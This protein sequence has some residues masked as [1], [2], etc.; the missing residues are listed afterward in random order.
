M[1]PEAQEAIPALKQALKDKDSAARKASVGALKRV[2]GEEEGGAA[3][4]S[5]L[6]SVLKSDPDETLRRAAAET[7]GRIGQEARV[8]I[9][10]LLKALWDKDKLVPE[11]IMEALKRID[12]AAIATPVLITM[13][14]TAKS[15]RRRC[16]A[17]QCLERIG[18]EAQAAIPALIEA[19]HDPV[20]VVCYRAARAL[21]LMG[22][23]AQEALKQALNDKYPGAREAAAAALKGDREGKG[24]RASRPG[25]RASI[26]ATNHPRPSAASGWL[27]SVR[28]LT[29]VSMAFSCAPL[30]ALWA[31]GE[32]DG[33][34]LVFVSLPAIPYLLIL[35]GLQSKRAYGGLVISVPIG[36]VAFLLGLVF[37]RVVAEH[38][39]VAVMYLTFLGALS[40]LALVSGAIVTRRLLRR[41]I[42]EMPALNARILIKSALIYC[43]PVLILLAVAIPSLL[44]S[45]LASSSWSAAREIWRITAAERK[46]ASTYNIGYSPS[47]AALGPPASGSRPSAASADLIDSVLASGVKKVYRFEYKPGPAED[48]RIPTYTITARPI[49]YGVTATNSYL[50][51]QTGIIRSTPDDRPATA[52]D[53]PL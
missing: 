3:A 31:A 19:L 8:A 33:R 26:S 48:G 51:D 25:R 17:A 22:P 49:E 34:M 46:Y 37:L 14:K 12:S 10:A 4:V 38:H 18:H 9:P 5:E 50:S 20:K 2:L 16:T 41:E 52:D 40:Q 53:P 35:E 15:P 11:H 42:P 23:E 29:L 47:L 43:V 21:G 27:W 24:R 28:I 39:S 44:R 45:R 6:V 1:G 13:L 30:A 7:L 32:A 36:S